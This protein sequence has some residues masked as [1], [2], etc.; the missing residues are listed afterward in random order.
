MNSAPVQSHE[1]GTGRVRE[2]LNWNA[3]VIVSVVITRYMFFPAILVTIF[4]FCT[5]HGINIARFNSDRVARSIGTVWWSFTAQYDAIKEQRGEMAAQNYAL[6][7][8]ILFSSYVMLTLYTI[9]YYKALTRK[10]T[11]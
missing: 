6:F 5:S 4:M 10:K 3:F 1:A 9:R 7:N 2:S 11:S 8:T